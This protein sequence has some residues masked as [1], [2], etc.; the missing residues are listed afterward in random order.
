MEFSLATFKNSHLE[1]SLVSNFLITSS[2][3]QYSFAFS[4]QFFH[5]NSLK[6]NTSIPIW[7]YSITVLICHFFLSYSV[8]I[9][10]SKIHLF[11]DNKGNFLILSQKAKIAILGLIHLLTDSLIIS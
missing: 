2:L 10:S 9:S 1:Y 3:I 6:I 4:F 8:N 5:Q 11:I 7:L